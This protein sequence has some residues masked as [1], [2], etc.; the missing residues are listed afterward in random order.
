[1]DDLKRVFS[2]LGSM[3]V[4]ALVLTAR[5]LVVKAVSPGT[6]AAEEAIAV[7]RQSCSGYGGAYP[8]Y[9]SLAAWETDYGGIDFGVHTVGDL[10]AADKIAV[11]RIE[12]TWTQVDTTRVSIGG[13][14]TDADHYIRIYTAP[15]ARHTGVAGSGYRLASTDASGVL[16]YVTVAYLRVEG[17]ELHAASTYSGPVIY[18]RPNTDAGVGEIHFSH[19]LIHGNRTAT[20]HGLHNYDCR[21]MVKVWN[22]IIYDVGVAGST[23]GIMNGVGTMIAYNNTVVDVVAG[24]ALRSSGGILA[25]NNLADAPGT[26]YYGSFAAGS[27]FNASTDAS[28]PG[29]HSRRNQT[30]V[31]ANRAGKNFH[32]AATDTGARNY[33]LDLSADLHLP[34][35]DD[36]DGQTR[37]GGWDI[38][39][40]ETSGADTIP[41]VRFNS[42]PS[43]TLPRGTTQAT[44]SLSTNETATCRYAPTS[45][46]P[47][48]DMPTTF[49]ATGGVTHT[50]LV[51]GLE[52][53][54][55]YAYYVRC[56]DTA[57]NANTDDAVISFDVFSSDVTPPVISNVQAVNITPY[58]AEIVWETDEGCTSQVEHGIG[59]DYGALTVLSA[60]RVMSHSVLLTGLD[61]ATT[62]HVR[63]R[64]QDVAYNET[65][66]TD[67]PFTTGAL[68]NFYYVDQQHPQASDDNPGTLAAPWLTIQHAAD[69]AQPGD[70]VIVYPGDYGRVTIRNGGTPGNYIT[71]KGLHVPDQSLINPNAL[72]DPA[73]PV[74]TLG[75]PAVNAVT[76]GFAFIRPYGSTYLIG[77]VRIENFEITR[78]YRPDVGIAGRGGVQLANTEHVQ[79]VRNFLHDLNPN[80]SGYD[81]IGIRADGHANLGAV[82]KDNTLY[83]V[84][85]TGISVMGRDW[86]VEGNALSHGLD[87]NTDTGAHVGGD[88]DA[89]RFFGSGHVIRNNHFRDYLDEEQ[90]GDPHIDCFQTFAVYP[91]SQFAYDILVEGNVCHNFGQMLMVSDNDAGD[92]VHHL[93][94]RNNIFRGARAYAFQGSE[95][96]YLVFVNNVVAESNYGAF[97][98]G[99]SPYMAILNNVFYNN[100]SG[101]QVNDEASKVELVWDYNLHYPDFSWPSKQPEFDQHSLFGVDPGFVNAVAGD[102]R[103]RVDSPAIDR[104]VT[105]YEFN[106]DHALTLRPQLVGWD[107]G[108]YEAVP[109][110]VLHGAPADRAIRLSWETNATL[111]ATSTWRITYESPGSVFLPIANLTN[112]LRAYTLP[113]LTNGV[114][115]TVTLDAMLDGVPFLTD[116]VR[117]MPTDRFVYLPLVQKGR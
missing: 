19:N 102:Y 49:A 115:Y 8:C 57:G 78:I 100:G 83:R 13:W 110:L 67:H 112:T 79:L 54:H 97:G 22:N 72:F 108:A 90:Y 11:A 4:L 65:L 85:G 84:Q 82:V 14:A 53:E 34:I 104:G 58:S 24:F 35:A 62:Y 109:Q 69:V 38:G 47:Y 66:S 60:T 59:V 41:P 46:V 15:E 91:D 77:Y 111:P 107:I 94:F 50:H 63:V 55:T 56:Q 73:H 114:W 86:L 113:G 98:I 81:Y 17:L 39:A 9:E 89:M 95:V 36:I 29:L 43:G 74:L 3:L 42:A 116:T 93:T 117:V 16:L 1:M 31:F 70:T 105:R 27:D 21:G 32:L 48:V 106:Y 23:A 20:G 7:I 26:D 61:P 80:P 71:F 51:T 99:D 30:F 37:S 45:G 40:D 28:A 18:L 6:P 101:A 5:G 52:G 25:R 33:G 2:L 76:A 87:A 10:I 92:Y 68:V 88:S 96:E 64:S 75:N 44:L 12:G 103:L